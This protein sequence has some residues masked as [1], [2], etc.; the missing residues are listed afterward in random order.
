MRIRGVG[1]DHSAILYALQKTRNTA[2]DLIDLLA[3]RLGSDSFEI[4]NKE[5]ARLLI[6]QRRK[7][8][9]VR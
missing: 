5:L 1:D 6:G 7:K 8:R 9:L 3:L 2:V 4:V